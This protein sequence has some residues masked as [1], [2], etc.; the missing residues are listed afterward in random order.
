MEG[1]RE[2]EADRSD[3]IYAWGRVKE[4]RMGKREKENRGS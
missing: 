3:D 4:G 1:D 2:G